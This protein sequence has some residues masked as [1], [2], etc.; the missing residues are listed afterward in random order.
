M[1]CPSQEK[2]QEVFGLWLQT[3]EAESFR[4][5]EYKCVGLKQVARN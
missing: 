3:S 1:E 5:L 4:Q 2:K